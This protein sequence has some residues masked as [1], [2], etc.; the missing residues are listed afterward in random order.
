MNFTVQNCTK[1]GLEAYDFLNHKEKIDGGLVVHFLIALYAIFCI[2]TVCDYYF[3]PSMKIMSKRLALPS[4]VAGATLLATSAAAPAFFIAL[5]GC[6][7]TKD[8]LGL[9]TVLGSCSI[10]THLM[11]GAC[12]LFA[13][14]AV[15]LE[16]WPVTRDYIYYMISVIVLIVIIRDMYVYWYEALL[17]LTFYMFYLVTLRFQKSIKKFWKRVYKFLLNRKSEKPPAG[18]TKE[19]NLKHIFTINADKLTEHS[20]GCNVV[21]LQITMKEDCFEKQEEEDEKVDMELIDEDDH[22]RLDLYTFPKGSA[23]EKAIWIIR[24]PIGFLYSITIPDCTKE[25]FKKF[26]PLTF[27]LAL[28]YIGG[29]TYTL[30]LMSTIIGSTLKIP[31]SVMAVSVLALAASIPDL[32][33]SISVFRQG[34]GNMALSTGLGCN[35]IDLLID[36]GLPWLIQASLLTEHHFVETES[37]SFTYSGIY[38]VVSA[39]LLYLALVVNGFKI[40]RRLAFIGFLFYFGF[41]ATA[42]ILE[43]NIF[44][45]SSIRVAVQHPPC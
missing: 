27:G 44:H 41:L 7:V 16:W 22:E 8:D 11:T 42:I 26:Y 14:K 15:Q 4:D 35:L 36:L 33:C 18:K 17:L 28:I 5:I 34:F 30:T 10:S 12:A 6:F 31:D 45:L 25:K 23:F 39:L 21:T 29:F 38:V 2:A 32:Y 20:F 24:W 19:E 13:A 40:N 9:V 43:L 1:A 3:I 37:N